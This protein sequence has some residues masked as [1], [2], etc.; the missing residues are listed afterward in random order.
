MVLFVSRRTRNFD[1][2]FRNI[3]GPYYA[4]QLKLNVSSLGGSEIIARND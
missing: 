4:V 3:I 2:A 1:T